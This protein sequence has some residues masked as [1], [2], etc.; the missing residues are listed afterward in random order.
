MKNLNFPERVFPKFIVDMV[1]H[2]IKQTPHLKS[3]AYTSLLNVIGFSLTHKLQVQVKPNWIEKPNFFTISI[4]PSGIGKTNTMEVYLNPIR[5]YQFIILKNKY[6]EELKIY[7]QFNNQKKAVEKALKS[8]EG[9]DDELRL[10]KQWLKD[11]NLEEHINGNNAEDIL[12]MSK[13]ELVTVFSEKGTMQGREKIFVNNN[14]RPVLFYRDEFSGFF[15]DL[16]RFNKGG[17][18]EEFLKYFD[19]TGSSTHNANDEYTRVYS[20]KCV[21]VMGATQ[22][23]IFRKMFN[24]NTIDNGLFYRFLFTESEHLDPTN[25]FKLSKSDREINIMEEYN[26]MIKRFLIGYDNNNPIHTIPISEDAYMFLD[27]KR[28]EIN[29]TW[30]EKFPTITP[31]TYNQVMGKMDSYWHRLAIVLSRLNI[32]DL[33][34]DNADK[35]SLDRDIINKELTVSDYSDAYTLMEYYIEMSFYLLTKVMYG[36]DD[37]YV[38]E[39]V[40]IRSTPYWEGFHLPIDILVDDCYMVYDKTYPLEDMTPSSDEELKEYIIQNLKKAVEDI[41]VSFEKYILNNA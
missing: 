28:D 41:P 27:K 30:K 34:I 16:N 29:K 38:D 3:M 10:F 31:E 32:Y 11:N 39:K 23:K 40:L 36:V 8:K 21:N 22:P 20:S 17:D 37:I 25:V 26:N 18:V 7:T 5:D 12:P 35:T 15:A 14:G 24:S 1:N 9:G 4:A 6:E 2:N 19:Y 13:P 33:Y